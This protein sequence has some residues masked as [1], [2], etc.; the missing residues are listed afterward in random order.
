MKRVLLID[1]SIEAHNQVTNAIVPEFELVITT[2]YSEARQKLGKELFS[3]ILLEASLSDGDGFSFCN[4]LKNQDLLKYIPVI[5]LT[6]KSS[7]SDK[8]R[9]FKIGA[10]DYVVKPFEPLELSLRIEARLRQAGLRTSEDATIKLG[11]LTLSIPFQ[12]ASLKEGGVE[13]DLKLTPTEFRLLYYFIKNEGKILT[14]DQLLATVWNNDVQVL[15][16]TIDKHISTLKKKLASLA[17]S[18][19]SIHGRGYRFYSVKSTFNS[20][21]PSVEIAV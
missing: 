11:D 15:T 7:L 6:H 3:L 17:S 14:R 13:K 16:R 21:Q 10:D 8:I 18:I 9:G 4:E 2:T 20:A 12:K 5:F 1:S 19:Q